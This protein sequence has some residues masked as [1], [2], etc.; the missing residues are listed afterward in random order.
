MRIVIINSVCGVKS[1]GRIC[2][3]IATELVKQGHDVKIAYG[4][5]TVPKPYEK[6]AVRIGNEWN[7][8]INAI[9]CR[10]F[11]NDGFAAKKTTKRFLKWLDEYNPDLIW[12]HN[13]HGYYINITLLFQWIKAH[14]NLRVKWTFHDPWALTGHCT[15]FD[16]SK[17][18]QW[19]T[20]C[21]KCEMRH[22]YPKAV[23][24][25]RSKR[26]LQ[27][28]KLLF[29]NIQN[30]EII[31]PSV[32]LA[33]LV[34]ISYLGQYSIKVVNNT[35]N[36]SVFRPCDGMFL[37]K[38]G[39]ANKKVVLGVTTAWSTRKG[40][41]DFIKLSEII[42]SDYNVVLVGLTAEQRNKLPDTIYGIERTNDVQ[43][44]AEI[45]SAADVF[46]NLS[47]EENYPTVN[48]EAQ[49]C[50]TPVITYNTGGSAENVNL[51]YGAVVSQGD[52]DSVINEIK[53]ITSV[54]KNGKPLVIP[55]KNTKWKL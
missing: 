1:T 33:N 15:S 44:L 48:I 24:F 54:Q 50:G 27:K 41:N 38:E 45:Y 42:H 23:L 22:E 37:K 20:G 25:S 32:W 16:Y 26:N 55:Y 35:V 28:K 4:R 3:D 7:V 19:K 49:Q 46:L 5:E 8:K 12:L 11:D 14:K 51:Q 47:Y 21:T 17:C 13:L 52:L 29:S 40:L 30:M 10:L 53:R 9:L 34:K 39:L 43:E 18:K 31:T 6:Y 36:N 2:T